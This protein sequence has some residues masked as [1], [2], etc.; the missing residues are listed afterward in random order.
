MK[1]E[2]I[3]LLSDNYAWLLVGDDGT[4]AVVDPAE[5]GPVTERV[6]GGG[7]K[8]AWIL[9]THHHWDH[10]GGIEDLLKSFSGVEVICSTTDRGRVP[11]ATRFVDDGERVTVAGCEAECLHVPGHTRGAVAYHFAA[12]EAVITG[13]TMFLAGC[14]RLFEGTPAQMHTS[15]ARLAEL[16]GSTRVYCGHEYT[17]KNMRFAASVDPDNPAVRDRLA[18]VEKQRQAGDVTV[19]ALL[20]EERVTSPF[21]RVTDPV[22]Q[23]LAGSSNPVEVFADLRRRRDSF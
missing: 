18:S 14:G 4:C 22:F 2:A 21:L 7:L 10:V 19:P 15:L 20:A 13:D 9:A 3:P 12:D 17:E 11:A 1:I 8:L 23:K 6:I 16:P 5:A